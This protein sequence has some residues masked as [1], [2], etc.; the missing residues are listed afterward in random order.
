MSLTCATWPWGALPDYPMERFR[1]SDRLQFAVNL[2]DGN[3]WVDHRD[4]TVRGTGIN[5]NLRHSYSTQAFGSGWS[6]NAGADMGLDFRT[7]VVIM[8]TDS[9]GCVQFDEKPGGGY[10]PATHGLRATLVKNAGGS[11]TARFIDSGQTWSFNADGWPLNRMDRNGNSLTYYYNSDGT[12]ASISDSQGR[13]TTFT[14]D[15]GKRITRITDPSGTVAG[16]YTFNSNGELTEFVDRDGKT[17]RLTYSTQSPYHLTSLTDQAGRTW[18]FGYDAYNR[19]NSV[20]TPRQAGAVQTLFAYDSDTQTTLTDPNGHKTVYTLDEFGRQI[21][22]KDALGHTQSQTWT[23]NSDIQSTTDGLNNSTTGTYDSLNN[24]ISTKLPTGATTT[25]GYISTAHPNQPTSVKDPAGNE[26]TLSYDSAGNI[27]KVRSTQLAADLEVRTYTGPRNLL[28]TIKDGNGNTTRFGYDNAGNLTSVTPPSPLGVTR[29]TYDSL[30]RVTSVT[31]GAGKR[32]DYAYDKL[33]RVVSITSGGTT[34]QTMTYDAVGAI[35]SRNHGGVT[36]TFD[37]D[38]Y[39]TG[40]QP[41][42]VERTQAGSTETVSYGYDNAGNLTSLTDPAG[43][44]TYT[45]DAANRLTTLADAFGQSTTFGYDDAD[46]RTSTTF[47]GAGTQ[48]NGYDDSGRLSTLTVKNTGGTELLKATYRYTTSTGADRTQLQSKTIAGA[49]TNY[50]YDTQRHLT[51]AGS[52]TYTVDKADN[53]TSFAGTAHTINAA[54]QLTAAGSTALTYDTAGNLT[55]T[56]PSTA[57]TYSDTNQLLRSTTS[58]AT[59]FTATYDTVDHTQPRTITETVSGATNQRVLTH[60]TLGITTLTDNGTRTSLAR[61]PDGTI[62]TEKIGGSRYNVI[63]DHQGSVL[64]L[65]ATTGTLAA[66]YTYTPYGDTSPAAGTATAN[67]FRYLGGHTLRNGTVH[68]GHRYYNPAWGRFTTL[69]PTGQERNLYAYAQADPINRTDP[70]G[71]Y[72]TDDFEKD[73]SIVSGFAGSGAAAGG[74]IGILACVFGPV[75]CAAGAGVGAA[76]GG[77]LGFVAGVAYVITT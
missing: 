49:T 56:G 51:A 9:G 3:L 63:T 11:Y 19:V 52:A 74:G 69:D 36:T 41:T 66:T 60:T 22:A 44:H 70:T 26:Q 40:P 59:T 13:V 12:L 64:A 20:T 37:H 58:G 35:T 34:L 2:A 46:R 76:V 8:P 77:G 4:L 55:G 16:S 29:Y 5:L 38:T 39:P 43:T 47:P 10:E 75:G 17:V 57:H 68:F 48:T 72:S 24:L 65:L 33:D 73:L 6:V 54:N 61:D 14:S 21:S 15:A 7:G 23:A 18:S 1:I 32:V 62:I 27:T 42:T 53:V 71:A 31:D 25:I 67:P 50:T 45:Y 30:S 28:E